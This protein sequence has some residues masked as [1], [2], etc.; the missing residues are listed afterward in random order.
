MPGALVQA[1]DRDLAPD[2]RFLTPDRVQVSGN[3]D[4]G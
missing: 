3:Q 4:S 1:P 2:I